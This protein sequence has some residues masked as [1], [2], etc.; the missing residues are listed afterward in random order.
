[1]LTRNL[2]SDRSPLSSLLIIVINLFF[3]FILVGPMVGL[4]VA[5]LFYEGD[6]INDIQNPENHPGVVGALLITQSVAT[7]V[8]L[9]LF[10][11]I[12]ITLIERKPLAPFFPQQQRTG[13]VFFLLMCLGLTFIISISPLVEWNMDLKFPEFLKEFET[14]ARE[15]EDRT[16]KLTELM[17]SFAS[18]SE[19][20]VGVFVI[21]LLPAIGEELVFRGMF[22]TEL[23]RATRNAHVAI[24]FAALI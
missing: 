8:G 10:P 4:G 3:G 13:I 5:W 24:W 11:V 15:T 21:A 9:I 7:F 22:Q 16:A 6:L 18:V 12:Q 14:W 20:L 23:Y 1:M 17:T 2:V 19:L